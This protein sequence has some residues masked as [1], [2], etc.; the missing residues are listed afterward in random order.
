MPEGPEKRGRQRDPVRAA[1]EFFPLTSLPTIDH[2]A[3]TINFSHNGL[4]FK[5]VL[6]LKVDQIICIRQSV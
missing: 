6:P 5:S 2:K 1:I 3:V 4:R